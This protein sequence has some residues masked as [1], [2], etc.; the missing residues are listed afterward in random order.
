[1]DLGMAGRHAV[2]VGASRGIGAAVTRALVGE[3]AAVT[4]VARREAELHRFC[5]ELEQLGA[6]ATPIV[7]D[8]TTPAG[9]ARLVDGLAARG[10]AVDILVN[11]V[12][13]ARSA[14]VLE[15]GDAEWSEALDTN[16]NSAVRL[17]AALVP[18]MVSRRWGRV[19]HVGSIAAREPGRMA[20]AYAAA[21]AALVAYSKALSAEV[22]RYGVLSNVV[23]PGATLTPSFQAEAV[24]VAQRLGITDEEATRRVMGRRQPALGRPCTA[25]EV[26]N[27]V[28]FLCSDAARAITGVSLPVD[29]GTL[30]GT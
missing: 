13:G 23:L 3:G 2:V 27:A 24:L 4:A 6:D 26:A 15:L 17:T 22:S 9:T 11:N 8:A 21:K 30:L 1:M 10:V 14:P 18:G 7:A 29:G 28:V 12:G 16:L 5:T 20:A 19:V 25:E